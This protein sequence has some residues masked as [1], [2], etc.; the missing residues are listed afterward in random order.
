MTAVLRVKR[1]LDDEPLSALLIACKRRKI[2]IN[3]EAEESA[4][5]EPL[6][7]VV[8][9]AGT[10]NN[11]ESTAVKHLIQS[12]GKDE[13]EASFKQ[14]SVD[15]LNKSREMM[16]QAS[17]ENRYKVINCMRSLDSVTLNDSENNEMTVIDVEDSISCGIESEEHTEEEENYV[18]DLYYGL[19]ENSVYMDRFISVLPFD[20][21]LVFDNYRDHYPEAECESEDSNSESNWRNDYPDSDHS[22]TSIN[23]NDMREAMMDMKLNND[24]DASNDSDFV[25]AVDE[26]DV[27]AYGYKYARYKAKVK[28]QLD[29]DGSSTSVSSPAYFGSMD[30]LRSDTDSN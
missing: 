21:E 7:T 14:H 12:V 11:Q 24:S 18:Y 1:R 2:S 4:I 9:F 25:Y 30:E 8:T 10:V 6:T 16:K 15:I 20:E 22:V 17:A 28:E 13:L 23:E 26:A 5:S 27:D 3:E 19:T 29:E